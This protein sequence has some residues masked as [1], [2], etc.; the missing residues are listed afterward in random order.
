MIARLAKAV[1]TST[2]DHVLFAIFSSKASMSVFVISTS[3]SVKI[4]DC[5]GICVTSNR[6]AVGGFERIH[7]LGRRS[8]LLFL[9]SSASCLQLPWVAIGML[10]LIRRHG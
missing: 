2:A 6:L 3:F 4:P 10:I 5:S 7:C 1:V 8:S 9:L